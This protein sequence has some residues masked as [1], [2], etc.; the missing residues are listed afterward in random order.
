MRFW[1]FNKRTSEK[2]K[3][4]Q[5]DSLVWAANNLAMV[6]LMP[7]VKRFPDY[8]PIVDSNLVNVWDCLMT[9][10]MTGVAAHE[11]GKLSDPQ[12]R[13]EI[14]KALH[15][16]WRVGGELFDDYYEYTVQQTTRTGVH[17]SAVSAMWVAEN[18]RLHDRAN[19]VLKQKAKELNFINR[20]SA[21]MNI[22]FGSNEVGLSNYL[23]IM[24][25]EV[26][27]EKDPEKKAHILAYIFET[28]ACKTVDLM[29]DKW[30]QNPKSS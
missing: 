29:A 14:K 6:A 1:P 15:E 16:K 28:F 25:P 2:L 20:L 5:F 24:T 3:A 22:S 12:T 19:S 13:K 9:I 30:K 26:N 17:W 7:L 27:N 18:L 4:E 10:A 11:R 21:F 23:G 8:G